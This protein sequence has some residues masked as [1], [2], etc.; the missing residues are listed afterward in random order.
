MATVKEVSGC[1]WI[2]VERQLWDLACSGMSKDEML[3][4]V[5]TPWRVGVFSD[6]RPNYSREARL[7]VDHVLERYARLAAR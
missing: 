7:L 2:F 6:G 4:A 3:A 1:A 5:S